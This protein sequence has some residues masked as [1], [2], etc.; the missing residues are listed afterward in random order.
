MSIWDSVTGDGI[1]GAAAQ[2]LGMIGGSGMSRKQYH[3]QKKLMGFQKGHQM[4]LNRHGQELAMDMWN[5]TNYKAQV[6]HMKKAGLN[7]ALMYG[8]AGQGGSTN[9]S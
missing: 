9:R 3:R 8:S 7:P 1:I 6:D 5:Q 2:G 4:D